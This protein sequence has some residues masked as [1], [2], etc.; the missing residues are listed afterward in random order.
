MTVGA[1]TFVSI[2]RGG[3][4]VGEHGRVVNR[5]RDAIRHDELEYGVGRT[6]RVDLSVLQVRRRHLQSAERRLAVELGCHHASIQAL[7]EKRND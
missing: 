7:H 6:T 3:G 5:Q 2:E 1:L 4:G